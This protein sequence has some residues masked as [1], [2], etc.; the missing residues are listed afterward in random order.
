[1]VATIGSVSVAAALTSIGSDAGRV[2]FGLLKTG[3]SSVCCWIPIRRGGPADLPSNSNR[4]R[5]VS[6]AFWSGSW[7]RAGHRPTILAEGQ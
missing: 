6:W 5:G 1:M 4:Q 7:Q 3:G 2:Q